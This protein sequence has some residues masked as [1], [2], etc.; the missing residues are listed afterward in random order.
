MDLSMIRNGDIGLG[1]HRKRSTS[2]ASPY[3]SP[4][5]PVSEDSFEPLEITD[6]VAAALEQ[7]FYGNFNQE[8]AGEHRGPWQ[9]RIDAYR[10][11][12]RDRAES[13]TATFTPNSV[14][15]TSILSLLTHDLVGLATGQFS[16]LGCHH[17]EEGSAQFFLSGLASDNTQTMFDNSSFIGN[18][19][20]EYGPRQ[21]RKSVV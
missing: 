15:Y 16:S 8:D 17:V 21:R 1:H 14:K 10:Q 18:P 2:G 5:G 13:M 7:Q 20:S 9:E 11:A 12:L 3:S 6:T 19:L 4:P